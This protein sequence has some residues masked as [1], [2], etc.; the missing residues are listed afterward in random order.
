MFRGKLREITPIRI[1]PASAQREITPSA[2][3]SAQRCGTPTRRR[4]T[5]SSSADVTPEKVQLYRCV[6]RRYVP[7]LRYGFSFGRIA[8][9]RE[10][11]V[12]AVH[13][14]RRLRPRDTEQ[15]LLTGPDLRSRNQNVRN[16]SLVCTA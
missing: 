6:Y 11:L 12:D 5:P 2:Y 1:A 16:A 13:R 15:Q 14:A 8:P 3:G 7:R 4:A 9:A 10:K